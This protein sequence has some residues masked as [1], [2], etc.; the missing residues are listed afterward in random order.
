VSVPNSTGGSILNPPTA[1]LPVGGNDFAILGGGK[2]AVAGKYSGDIV[3]IYG[4][5]YPYTL[6]WGYAD[7]PTGYS[8][9]KYPAD[10]GV[11]V[12]GKTT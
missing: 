12:G 4:S 11:I 6:Q 1:G 8:V 2:Y 10:S 5:S 7:D 3:R 9:I